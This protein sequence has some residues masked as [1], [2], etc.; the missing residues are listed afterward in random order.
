LGEPG[1]S[2]SSHQYFECNQNDSFKQ[3]FVS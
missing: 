3:H 1:S 2:G